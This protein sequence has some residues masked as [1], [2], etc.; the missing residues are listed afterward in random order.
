MR[1]FT[2]NFSVNVIG[3]ERK[4]LQVHTTVLTKFRN[5][6]LSSHSIQFTVKFILIM[7]V[8]CTRLNNVLKFLKN[9]GVAYCI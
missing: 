1:N 2:T 6:Q 3:E 8:G 5:V 9:S 7:V 4:G